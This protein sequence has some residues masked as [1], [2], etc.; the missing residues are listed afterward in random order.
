M[1][2]RVP[3][4]DALVLSTLSEAETVTGAGPDSKTAPDSPDS[5]KTPYPPVA[6]APT[7]S[8]PEGI[9]FDFNQGCR[10]VLPNRETGLWRV[11]LRDLDTGNPATAAGTTRASASTIRTSCGARAMPARRGNLNARG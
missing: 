4:G 5:Q 2:N 9:L 8:T 11:C 3:Q 1:V 6:P 7:Q 10:V